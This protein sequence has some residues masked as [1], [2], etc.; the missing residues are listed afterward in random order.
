[1]DCLK[2]KALTLTLSQRERGRCLGVLTKTEYAL[3][4][5]LDVGVALLTTVPVDTG[6]LDDI[7]QVFSV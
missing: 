4:Y 7:F 5:D 1:V 3:M 2:A 6:T